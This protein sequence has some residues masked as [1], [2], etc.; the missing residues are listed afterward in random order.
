MT[1]FLATRPIIFK[2]YIDA[3]SDLL[4]DISLAGG[5]SLKSINHERKVRVI[6]TITTD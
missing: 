5:Q 3:R 1:D 4:L 6:Y 2:K